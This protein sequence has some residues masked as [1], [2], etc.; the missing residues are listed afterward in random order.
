[1]TGRNDSCPC[2]SGLKF[3]KCCNG[4]KPGAS[5]I[6]T[7][8]PI[9]KYTLADPISFADIVSAEYGEDLPLRSIATSKNLIRTSLGYLE[10]NSLL[11]ADIS[12]DFENRVCV[13]MV[14]SDTSEYRDDEDYSDYDEYDD[15]PDSDEVEV[16][17]TETVPNG[18][19]NIE[20]FRNKISS[21]ISQ[22]LLQVNTAYVFTWLAL[23]KSV[24]R[25]KLPELVHNYH[26]SFNEIPTLKKQRDDQ[27]NQLAHD[28]ENISLLSISLSLEPILANEKLLRNVDSEFKLPEHLP[29]PAFKKPA[30]LIEP[31]FLF[32]NST[33]NHRKVKLPLIFL[34]RSEPKQNSGWRDNNTLKPI[35]DSIHYC[36]S[37][38]AIISAGQILTTKYALILPPDLLPGAVKLF[39]GKTDEF[40]GQQN[41]PNEFSSKIAQIALVTP[42]QYYVTYRDPEVAKVNQVMLDLIERVASRLNS[43]RLNVDFKFVG[44][45]E[46]TCLKLAQI[47]LAPQM[48]FRWQASY[49][50]K[51]LQRQPLFS[52]SYGQFN[53]QKTAAATGPM[54][55]LKNAFLNLETKTIWLQP[56]STKLQSWQSLQYSAK[57]GLNNSAT[58]AISCQFSAWPEL[59]FSLVAEGIKSFGELKESLHANKYPALESSTPAFKIKAKSEI[60]LD[61][62]GRF[63]LIRQLQPADDSAQLQTFEYPFLNGFSFTALELLKILG[64]NISGHFNC[65]AKDLV[66]KSSPKRDFDLK[67]L[68]HTGLVNFL[69][70]EM[71]S[72]HFQGALSDGTLVKKPSDLL[73]L[74]ETKIV[75]LLAPDSGGA[76][77]EL[78]TKQAY[79]RLKNF[80]TD[81]QQLI[82]EPEK[83]NIRN[84]LLLPE[85]EFILPN[86][87]DDELRLIYAVL[88]HTAMASNGDVFTKGRLSVLSKIFPFDE[89]RLNECSILNSRERISLEA[90]PQNSVLFQLPYATANGT[91]LLGVLTA[92]RPLLNVNTDFEF[93]LK[94]QKIQ[95]LQSSEFQTEMTLSEV[96]PEPTSELNS[97]LNT[98]ARL[99]NEPI[100]PINWFELNPK[101]F[102][103]GTEIPAGQVGQLLKEGIIEHKGRFYLI[104]AGRLPSLKRLSNFWVR[105]QAGKKTGSG[106]GLGQQV[107]QVPKSQILEMLALRSSGIPVIGGARWKQVCDFYDQL[108]VAKAPLQL[109]RTIRAELKPYQKLGVQWLYELY[110]LGLGA[111][112]ADDMGLGKTLQALAFLE[113]LRDEKCMGPVLIVVPTSLTYNWLSE[114]EKFVPGL[115]MKVFSAKSK[116]DTLTFLDTN[117]HAVVLTTYG[118]MHEHK[119]YFQKINWNII[120][121]DEAQNLKTITTQRTTSARALNSQIKICLTGTPLE[122]HLGELYSILDLAVP[123]CLGD[124]DEFRK[125]FVNAPSIEADDLRFLKLKSK[126]L[127]LRRTKQQILSELP[128]KTESRVPLDFE[129]KQKKIYR[130]IAI[131]YN[132]KIQEAI[133]TQGENKCQLQMLTAL[134]RLRQACSDPSALPGVTYARTPPKLEALKD[135]LVEIVASGESAL[136]FTQFLRTLER[137]ET[138]LKASNLPTFTIHGGLSQSRREKVLRE[139]NE[140]PGGAVLV[141]T[142]KTGGVGLN[143]AKASYVF[144]LEPWWNP[145]V[146]NQATDRAHRM[147]QQRAVQVYRYIMHE[148]VEEKIEVLKARKQLTFSAVF[149]DDEHLDLAQ[150]DDQRID[151]AGSFLSKEDFN[152]LLSTN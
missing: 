49:F 126:P 53:L 112:L 116:D 8:K 119:D 29:A 17:F 59:N 10:Q 99:T 33:L 7:I 97:K 102:L 47:Q 91:G 81:I 144:H 6:K 73:V 71:L 38:G 22:N 138:L 79:G 16:F 92:F 85:G 51:P 68:R 147:G 3:K 50:A 57:S 150:K 34:S 27:R 58:T 130:D 87:L 62:E 52:V 114:K 145:A 86:L 77:Q 122:N 30:A 37:D 107:Y 134:L 131:S 132:D 143:L 117:P 140:C 24:D 31:E 80:V 115:S 40:A 55:P 72:V 39:D 28:L 109:P 26:R 74:L 120:I 36:F 65:A 66:S 60:H 136:V 88:V 54:I 14:F 100:K 95:E 127:I 76:L 70:L 35:T 121:F 78:C 101:F 135:S 125:I 32:G 15:D 4:L 148:S 133:T 94:G 141:M 96:L 46:T 142:L 124:V 151:S 20:I 110:S 25:K 43:G 108:D 146:E 45:A 63:F 106:S 118:M 48:P 139:F 69:I 23:A 98:S 67:L 149:G 18:A 13:R 123:G 5:P 64:D 93:Y 56:V 12:V 113:K 111:I 103:Y 90:R 128:A 152:F 61:S 1:M 42:E 104:P 11:S 137:A 9:R 2:G 44:T 129:D 82:G 84:T 21:E 83:N 41:Q 19:F 75:A 89:F 105:L